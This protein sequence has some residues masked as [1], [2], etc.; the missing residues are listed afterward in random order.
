[1]I[2]VWKTGAAFVLAIDH[3]VRDL[4]PR[5]KDPLLSPFVTPCFNLAFSLISPCFH[6]LLLLGSTLLSA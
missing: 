1:M 5:M 6:P 2:F 4:E 3:H